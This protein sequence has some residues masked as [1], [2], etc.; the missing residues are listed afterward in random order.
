MTEDKNKITSGF[1]LDEFSKKSEE[2]C[3]KIKSELEKR[4]RG[5]YAAL[6]FETEKY[7]IGETVSDALRI[8]KEEFP[9]KLFYLIQIGSP[10]TFTI[11]SNIPMSVRRKKSY[12][13][14][15]TY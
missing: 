12:D 14:S 5:K 8:A 10:S 3:N 15:W 2:F 11:Q 13:I 6:D 1:N 7:W 9:N 4:S